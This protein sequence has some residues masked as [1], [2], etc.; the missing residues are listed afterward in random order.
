MKMN[1]KLVGYIIKRIRMGH[2]PERVKQALLSAGWHPQ[3]VDEHI[4]HVLGRYFLGSGPIKQKP[5]KVLE[6]I[7]H[8][9]SS[10]SEKYFIIALILIFV[11]VAS[12]AGFNYFFDFGKKTEVKSPV[13]I[14]SNE[15]ENLNLLNKALIKNDEIICGEIED[16]NL[17]EQCKDKFA[18][19]ETEKICDEACKDQEFLNL[20]LIRHNNSICL[21]IAD[22]S[23]KNQ[24]EQIFVK[25]G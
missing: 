21:Q 18:I 3:I 17:M 6:K 25:G 7:K 20:A 8:E 14:T 2:H 22:S 1:Q 15:S 11:I 12:V 16:A 4:R 19:N 9:L 13:S 24:C 5:K 23:L 10:N